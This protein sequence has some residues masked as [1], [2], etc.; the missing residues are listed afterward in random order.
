MTLHPVDDNHD[1]ASVGDWDTADLGIV[2][3]VVNGR[4]YRSVW[5]LGVD[6]MWSNGTSHEVTCKGTRACMK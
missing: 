3:V 1:L 2:Y 4:Y 6:S 5:T